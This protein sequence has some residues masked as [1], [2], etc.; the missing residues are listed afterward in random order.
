MSDKQL[1]Q[2]ELA[3]RDGIEDL[4]LQISLA[5]RDEYQFTEIFEIYLSAQLRMA[6]TM[7]IAS[8]CSHTCAP[9]DEINRMAEY[10]R[11]EMDKFQELLDSRN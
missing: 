9:I 4:L 7:Y 1:T 3:I 6:C 10:L 2:E 8:K 5:L 11:S